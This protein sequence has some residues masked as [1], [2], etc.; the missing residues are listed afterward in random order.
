ML[1]KMK[2]GSPFLLINLKTYEEAIENYL[3]IAK[4]A[5]NVSE[6]MNANIYIAPSHLTLKEVSKI[7]PTFAQSMDPYETGA[8]TGSITAEEVKKS[9]AIGVLINHSER[10]L[11]ASD[12]KNCVERCSKNGLVSMVCVADEKEAEEYASFNP[13]FVAIEP[14]ELIGGKVSVSTAKPEV[15]TNSI[16]AVKKVS[17]NV[18]VVCGA[19]IKTRQDV[20]RALQL[21][22]VGVLVS[23]GIV[24][25]T[26]IRDAIVDA[27]KGLV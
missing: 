20:E 8:H 11:S 18:E 1:N 7:L 17:K 9:G 15:V 10:R 12:V 16:K 3:Q 26:N 25:A 13:D 4:I 14:P 5:K 23:S 24:K 6:E 19:G 27:A 2:T 21:G 22:V